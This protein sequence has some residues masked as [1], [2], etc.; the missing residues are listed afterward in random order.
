[1]FS[2][3]QFWVL[4]AFV[5]FVVITFNPIRKKL[6]TDLDKKIND[7]KESID[8]AEK[9][10]NDTQQTLSEIKKRQNEV[11]Q[12]IIV[13]QKEARD[14]ISLIENNSHIKLKEQIN[15]RN[16]LAKIKIDQMTRD[17]NISVQ[18]YIAQTAIAATID[19]LVKKLNDQEKQKLINQSMIEL[20]SALKN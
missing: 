6:S 19:I 5:I 4:V 7:I 14:K 3:P 17:A 20:N 11:K 12:E 16:E 9:L 8:Q 18:K 15:K 10:K 2:D 13:M 1:M